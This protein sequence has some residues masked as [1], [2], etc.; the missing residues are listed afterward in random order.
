MQEVGEINVRGVSGKIMMLWEDKDCHLISLNSRLERNSRGLLLNMLMMEVCDMNGRGAVVNEDNEDN[1]C[2][3]T[4]VQVVP[5]RE[6]TLPY[7]NFLYLEY[8]Y[9]FDSVEVAFHIR[10]LNM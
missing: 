9:C 6:V 4:E 3:M 1:D 7:T 10:L 5:F 2:H 8:T